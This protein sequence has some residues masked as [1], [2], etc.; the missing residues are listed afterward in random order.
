MGSI[1]KAFAAGAGGAVVGTAAV[2][3]MP[4]GTPWYGYLAAYAIA[5]LA[6][7]IITYFAPKNS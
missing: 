1:S 2:P 5:I 4:E 6:P 3:Y 7:A